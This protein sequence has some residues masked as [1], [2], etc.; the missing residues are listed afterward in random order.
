MSVVARLIAC[1]GAPVLAAS[2]VSQGWLS[3]QGAIAEGE[4]LATGVWRYL[5]YFTVLTN[6]L[7]ALVLAR[8]ALKPADRSGL[9]APR[10]ELLAVT[11]ILFVGAVYNVLLASQWDPQGLQKINDD[12]LH[13]W[14]PL[15]FA[16]FWLM[17]ARGVLTW[18]DAAFAASWPLIYSIYGLARGAFDGF[19]PYFFINPATTPWVLVARNMGGLVI[20]FTLGALMLIVVDR[21]VARFSRRNA[22]DPADGVA[23]QG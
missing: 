20:V 14:A 23:V 22:K 7:V 6:A 21:A 17:R 19:Y 9:N 13:I 5:C 12:I 16:L 1:I 8:A 4:T 11:S 15:G 10:F 18:R 2:I 3:V